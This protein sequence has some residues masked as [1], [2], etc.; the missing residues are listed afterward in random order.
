MLVRRQ[1]GADTRLPW[2]RLF[3]DR[4]FGVPLSRAGAGA[5]AV[6]L[7]MLRLG[8]SASNKQPWR[9]VRDGGAW[10]FY[11]QR[12]KGY[13]GGLIRA[14]LH[15]ADI[16]RL[17]L[18]IAMCHFELTARELGLGGRW[19]VREPAIAKPD[20]LTEYTVSWLS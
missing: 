3:C 10:H 18:G 13:G 12:T 16:Q 7:E 14:L 5:Y 6:P 1:V 9:V 4:Q 17:D 11:L 2:E 15:T 8:P 19:E 20:A